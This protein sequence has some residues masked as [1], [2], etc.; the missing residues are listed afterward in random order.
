MP[1][2]PPDPPVPPG[3]DLR[4][5]RFMPLDVVR[6]RD[7]DLAATAAP[8]TFRAAMLLWCAAWHQ[9]PAG[10]LPD[11]DKTLAY[12][13]GF[14]RDLD[15]WRKCNG[16]AM[17]ALH[18][19]VKCTDGRLYH[20]VI[21]EK[22]LES[23]ERRKQHVEAGKAGAKS[24]WQRKKTHN[25]NAIAQPN[26]DAIGDAI[27]GKRREET[28][29]VPS[30]I[31][32]SPTPGS[33]SQNTNPRAQGTSL[34]QTKQNPR[35]LGQ[36]PR[37]QPNRGTRLLENWALP[38]EWRKWAIDQNLGNLANLSLEGKRFRDYWWAKAGKDATKRDWFATWRNWIRR[39]AEIAKQ[40]SPTTPASTEPSPR[41]LAQWRQAKIKA[42][43]KSDVAATT[44][45]LRSQL[46]SKE[47]KAFDRKVTKLLPQATAVHKL[48]RQAARKQTPIP[49]TPEER[50]AGLVAL[51]AQAK[52]KPQ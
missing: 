41:A 28:S 15:G 27:A 44:G 43:E 19:F 48:Q 6:L 16:D 37:K 22:V 24:R 30:P 10:S 13:A 45:K 23:I 7:S 25:D 36:N 32:P 38:D 11:D 49:M 26:G 47:R 39:A 33:R 34:R 40:H 17:A 18:G 3:T 9:I 35:A 46:T 8:E 42:Q 51:E 52:G 2:D 31:G 14:G 20:A 5:F 1:S 29:K 12:L 4:D 50:E 21:C